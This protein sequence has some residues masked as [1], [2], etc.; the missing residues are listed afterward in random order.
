M[1]ALVST[2]QL[3]PTLAESP[4]ELLQRYADE[5]YLDPKR[6]V[7]AAASGAKLLF[8][9]PATHPIWTVWKAGETVYQT[10]ELPKRLN[11]PRTT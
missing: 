5:G 11:T 8:Q 3:L 6:S 10:S 1:R 9:P 7:G 2:A 4:E